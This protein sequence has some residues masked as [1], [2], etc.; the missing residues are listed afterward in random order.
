MKKVAIVMGSD[1]DLGVMEKA[2]IYA[3]LVEEDRTKK[4]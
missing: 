1:S 3:K 4:V 2:D